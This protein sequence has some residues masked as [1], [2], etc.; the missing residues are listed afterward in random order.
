MSDR[1]VLEPSAEHP[2]TIAPTGGHVT[3]RVAGRTLAQSDAAVT[4]SEASYPPVVYVPL[5]DVDRSQI[6]ASDHQSYCPYKGNASYYTIPALGQSGE[7]A[8]WEYRD[9]RPAVAEIKDR[10]AF[11]A[12]R[13]SIE[14]G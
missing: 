4:L 9:P 6:V 11:Y 7:N 14:V 12:D 10:V 1:P 13:V 8:I 3:V 5:A 2:I